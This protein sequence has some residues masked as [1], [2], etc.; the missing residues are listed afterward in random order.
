MPDQRTYIKVHDGMDEHPKV[1]PLSDAAFRL[2][3][4]C[5]FWCSRNRTDGR[6]PAASWK[7]RGTP[8][9]RRELL[10]AGLA[11]DHE[12]HVQ[13]HDY[14]EHQR[15]AAQIDELSEKRRQAGRRGGRPKG[16][17]SKPKANALANAEQESKQEPKQNESPGNP[18]TE[19]L[20]NGSSQTDPSLRSGSSEPDGSAPRG[21]PTAQTVLAAWLQRQR[22]RPPQRFIG[23]VSQQVKALLTEGFAAETVDAGLA[24]MDARGLHPSTLPSLVNAAVNAGTV[25]PLRPDTGNGQ[26]SREQVDDL[27]GPDTDSLPQP[28]PDIDPEIDHARYQAWLKQARADRNAQRERQARAALDQLQGT[29]R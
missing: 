26:L 29:S 23:Q 18:V 14:L 21:A 7:Q 20:P 4:R 19:E 13:M 15:S 1:E 2:L 9:T 12:D 10:D 5:W 24:A 6:I 27:L 8:K 22:H 17:A 11:E 25:H 16:S 3:F 28:P